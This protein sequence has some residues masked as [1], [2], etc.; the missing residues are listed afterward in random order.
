MLK[1]GSFPNDDN[2]VQFF[3][4]PLLCSIN[5]NSFSESVPPKKTARFC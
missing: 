5:I 4:C 2:F 3:L 1:V